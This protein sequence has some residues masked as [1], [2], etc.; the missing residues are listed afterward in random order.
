MGFLSVLSL[1]HRWAS[2]RIQPGE[3]VID[4]TVGNGVDTLFLADRTGPR[5]SVYGFDI[6]PLALARTHERLQSLGSRLPKVSLY[7]ESHAR[8][9]DIIPREIVG[10]TAAVL[11]NLGYLP[12]AD[13]T[14]EV[15]TEPASTLTA[16]QAALT[17]LRPGGILSIVLYTG[18]PGGAEEA[19]A[20]T[21]WANGLPADTGQAVVYRM[22]QKPEA[23]YLIGIEK[24]E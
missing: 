4:A 10:Q 6:Q 19:G 17:V 2:E 5:G 18:H 3:P 12:G 23:P 14:K 22:I 9:L 21:A 16:M 8:M 13:D 20:V 11:F 1:A 15:I 24:K 7:L